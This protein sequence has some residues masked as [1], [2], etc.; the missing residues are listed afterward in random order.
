MAECTECGASLTLENVEENELVQ[1]NECG[2]EL[3]VTS[4]KPLKVKKAPEEQEDW[5]E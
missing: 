2:A 3:E 1:C 5:G 4:V